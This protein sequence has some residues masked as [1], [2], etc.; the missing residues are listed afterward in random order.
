MAINLFTKTHLAHQQAST[1]SASPA[2][3]FTICE[4]DDSRAKNFLDDLRNKGGAELRQ[5]VQRVA[6]GKE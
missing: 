5:R 6:T 1:G 2:P 4:Q 3:S